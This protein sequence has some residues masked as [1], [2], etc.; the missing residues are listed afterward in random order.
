MNGGRWQ[1]S[2]KMPVQHAAAWPRDLRGRIVLARDHLFDAY[3][4]GVVCSSTAT[5]PLAMTCRQG[6]D[7]WPVGATQRAF[8]APARNFFTGVLVPALGQ[9]GSVAPF[10]SAAALPRSNYT[11]WVL[12]RVDGT[13]HLLDGMNDIAMRG[14]RDWGNGL[15]AVQSA[16]G[17]GTQ[18]LV[19]AA[20]DDSSPDVLRAFEIA[21]REPVEASAPLDFSGPIAAL[22]TAADG[23]TAIAV[24]HN[25]KTGTYDA[26]ELAI[27]CGQ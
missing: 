10:Y 13:V 19:T 8:F 2:Q 3:L 11:L 23:R 1:P 24:A 17:S 27:T 7:P 9:Q 16:C 22:W 25:L 12:A 15:A 21:G 14:A 26:F 20:G 5:A 18:L 4:P 6:D